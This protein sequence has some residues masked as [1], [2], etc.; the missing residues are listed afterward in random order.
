MAACGAE[1]NVSECS[2]TATATTPAT[3][4]TTTPATATTTAPA[5]T[6]PPTEASGKEENLYSRSLTFNCQNQ[7]IL[8]NTKQLR[9]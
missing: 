2:A 1:D 6:Q 8:V 3:A 7:T 9:K 4:T 5:T